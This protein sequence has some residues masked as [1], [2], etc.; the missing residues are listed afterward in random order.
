MFKPLALLSLLALVACGRNDASQVDADG[1]GFVAAEDCRDNDA[2]SFPGAEEIC[3]AVDNDCDGE[4]DNGVLLNWY[5]DA[6]A[7]G[8][9]GPIEVQG[10]EVPA[11]GALEFN[12]CDDFNNRVNPEALEVC[13]GV[14]SGMG[15]WTCR[16]PCS[17]TTSQALREA[18]SIQGLGT[19]LG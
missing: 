17:A 12:D 1:D 6:D 18:R 9:G 11:S 15:T 14:D 16:T 10:C 4:I 2:A 19:T 3:D 5:I 8:F 7:D 13:D